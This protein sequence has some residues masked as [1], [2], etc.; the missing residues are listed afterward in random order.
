MILKTDMMPGLIIKDTNYYMS[1]CLSYIYIFPP[2]KSIFLNRL[3]FNNKPNV[4]VLNLS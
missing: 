2:A 4:L 1:I 3:L